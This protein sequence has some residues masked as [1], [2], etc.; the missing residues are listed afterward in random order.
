MDANEIK[1]MVKT[2]GVV[3]G[4]DRVLKLLRENQLES[5]YLAK[6]A[7]KLVVDDVIR[8][9]QLNG[10]PCEMLDVPNDELGI[11]CKKPFNVAAIGIKKAAAAAKKRH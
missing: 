2:T 5:A 4:S 10:V 11:L 9:A 7:P 6:N 3:L 1:K 8:Y